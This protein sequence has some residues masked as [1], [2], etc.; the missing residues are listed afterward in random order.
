MFALRTFDVPVGHIGRRRIAL[1]SETSEPRRLPNPAGLLAGDTPNI[2]GVETDSSISVNGS[3]TRH[4]QD[5]RGVLSPQRT[6]VLDTS[7]D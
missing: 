1:S 6:N 2:D 5:A 7:H 3:L 4:V